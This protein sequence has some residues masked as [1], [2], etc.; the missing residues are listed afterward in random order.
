VLLQSKY[1]RAGTSEFEHIKVNAEQARTADHISD[2]LLVVLAASRVID[3]GLKA[4]LREEDQTAY[5]QIWI[6]DLQLRLAHLSKRGRR[7]VVPNSGHDM[8]T[9]RPDEIVTAVRELCAPQN[10]P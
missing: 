8:P 9:D 10:Q 7:V 1:L 3:A 6:N 5:E 2:K 4:A